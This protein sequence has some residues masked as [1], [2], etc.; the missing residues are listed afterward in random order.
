MFFMGEEIV[1]QKTSTYDNIAQAK[2]DL[3]GERAGKGRCM[4]RFYQDLLDLNRDHAV[5]RSGQ[6]DIL[7]ALPTTRVVL[8]HAGQSRG[9][10]LSPA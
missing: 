7:H 3:H 6:I 4:F 8:S 2:E 1:A 9:C 10:S 5:V